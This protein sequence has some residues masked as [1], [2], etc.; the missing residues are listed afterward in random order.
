[1]AEMTEERAYQ[2][3]PVV[4]DSLAHNTKVLTPTSLS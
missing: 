1:M 4:N 3:S 2:I